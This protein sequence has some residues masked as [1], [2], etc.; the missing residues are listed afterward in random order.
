[1][2]WPRSD[3]ISRCR[4]D[5]RSRDFD[6]SRSSRRLHAHKDNRE[7]RSPRPKPGSFPGWLGDIAYLL[8]RRS[9]TSSYPSRHTNMRIYLVG[10]GG[11]VHNP[12]GRFACAPRYPTIRYNSRCVCGPPTWKTKNRDGKWK[13]APRLRHPRYPIGYSVIPHSPIG[14]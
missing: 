13:G 2:G 4:N 11:N 6:H 9:C 7:R 10:R 1:M 14:R 8:P 12:L 5:H 3:R